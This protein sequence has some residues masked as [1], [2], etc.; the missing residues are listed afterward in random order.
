MVIAGCVWRYP[1]CV[2]GDNTGASGAITLVRLAISVRASRLGTEGESHYRL[3]GL[4][5]AHRICESQEIGWRHSII[6]S[7]AT[8]SY[9][10]HKSQIAMN[11]RC[12]TLR[13]G[14]ALK[15]HTTF[16]KS[17]QYFSLARVQPLFTEWPNKWPCV[18]SPDQSRIA[19]V[20]DRLSL[21][22]CPVTG[23]NGEL[24]SETPHGTERKLSSGCKSSGQV[25]RPAAVTRILDG[26]LTAALSLGI[27]RTRSGAIFWTNVFTTVLNQ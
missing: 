27:G 26:C 23:V 25:I 15:P 10:L 2:W 21:S 1:R 12:I 20:P 7:A 4:T 14:C 13:V 22:S 8:A 11:G 19:S 3:S 5:D 17:Q 6:C 18:Q 9:S 16:F 24:C